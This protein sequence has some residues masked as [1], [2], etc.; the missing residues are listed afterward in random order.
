[1]APTATFIAKT[2][3]GDAERAQNQGP[4]Q[5]LVIGSLNT[6][7]DGTYQS[8]I[9]DLTASHDN[10]VE[11][12]LF[13]R[14]ID[15][16]APLVASSL[17][18]IHVLLSDSDYRKLL[19]PHFETFLS[20]LHSSLAPSG[21]ICIIN[22]APSVLQSVSSQLAASGFTI[23]SQTP[24]LLTAKKPSSAAASLKVKT[25]AAGV[26]ELSNST[27]PSVT[28]RNRRNIDPSRKAKAAAIWAVSLASAATIDPD[29]LLTPED[30]ARPIPTC[31]PPSSA[32][33]RAVKR[34][35]ACKGC[36]C[37][38]A[39]LE[40]EEE[41]AAA[42]H[43]QQQQQPVVVLDTRADNEGGLIKE[44]SL[45]DREKLKIAAQNAGKATS[46]CGS[47]FLGDAFRCAGCPY[48]GEC[49]Y[50]GLTH[51]FLR[52]PAFEPGQKVEIDFGMDDF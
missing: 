40:A 52:L 15:Q 3:P 26:V 6:A 18:E 23:S 46:S 8:L 1:M 34:K 16:A 11:K 37:G 25:T 5:V 9:S 2:A 27:P 7:Q 42:A 29:T 36:T 10:N 48:R 49:L 32:D 12:L 13:D 44:M 21:T 24:S 30:R 28:L 31:E 39:E 47:C 43:Y 4:K 20:T 35:R 19:I 33:G 38:L 51:F 50:L 14:I 22:P 45:S 17:D 41:E